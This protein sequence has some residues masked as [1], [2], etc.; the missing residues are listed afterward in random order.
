M[1]KP[2]KGGDDDDGEPG[3]HGVARAFEG[4]VDERRGSRRRVDEFYGD[5]A[6]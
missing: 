6:V 2:R 5:E 1:T 3:K 4:L